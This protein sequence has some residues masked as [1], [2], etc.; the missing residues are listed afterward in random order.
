MQRIW[1]G[2]YEDDDPDLRSL[3][4]M[5]GTYVDATDGA[6][7]HVENVLIDDTGW[8]V[9]YLIVDTGNWWMGKHVLISPYA[10]VNISWADRRMSLSVTNAAVKASPAWDPLTIIT[11]IE[12]RG[13]H[14]HYGWQGYG[15]KPGVRSASS[16]PVP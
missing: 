5:K 15:W 6:I 10:V 13:L 9:R 7:G 3:G 12:E 8:D 16:C 4:V 14:S 1:N 2:R 11:E